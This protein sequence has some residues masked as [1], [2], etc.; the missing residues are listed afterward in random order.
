MIGWHLVMAALLAA[1]VGETV[2]VKRE[3]TRLMKAPRFFGAACGAS[4]GPGAKVKL[5]EVKKGWARIAS[6][7]A[8]ACWLH[9]TAWSDRTAGELAG[10]GGQASKRDIELAGR[11][12]SEAEETRFKGEH[13]ELKAA[14]A[15]VETHLAGGA[16]PSPGEVARFMADGQLGGAP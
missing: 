5:V 2:T 1:G 12:F 15:A 16:E 13:G 9:E 6:P 8:G 14:Y 3:G 4:V 11:G 7:G 10:G